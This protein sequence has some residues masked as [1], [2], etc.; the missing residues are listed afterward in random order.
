MNPVPL[1]GGVVESSDVILELT[2]GGRSWAKS[3]SRSKGEKNDY[4]RCLVNASNLANFFPHASQTKGLKPS[5]NNMCLLQS[6]CLANPTIA[7]GQPS[8]K[9]LKGLSSLCERR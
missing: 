5:C 2:L 6:C 1:S 9:H 3:K 8:Y 4:S 7:F